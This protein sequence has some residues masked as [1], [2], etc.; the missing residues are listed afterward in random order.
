MVL[1]EKGTGVLEGSRKATVTMRRSR[2]MAASMMLMYIFLYGFVKR[3]RMRTARAARLMKNW[4]EREG[5]GGGM[6]A[7]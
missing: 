4:R 2:R 7:V 3:W 5:G 6:M 1:K